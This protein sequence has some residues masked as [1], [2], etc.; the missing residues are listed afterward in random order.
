M[1]DIK[2][3]FNIHSYEEIVFHFIVM[4]RLTILEKKLGNP[5]GEIRRLCFE[6]VPG[7]RLRALS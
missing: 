3:I 5:P 2:M 1:K 6:I 7:H 4:K